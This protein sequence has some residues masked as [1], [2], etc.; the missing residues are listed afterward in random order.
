MLIYID[1]KL[2]RFY[3]NLQKGEMFMANLICAK[4]NQPINEETAVECP[5]C[6]ELYHKECWEDSENCVTCKKYNPIYELAQMQKKYEEQNPQSEEKIQDKT[7]TI[8][9]EQNIE[10]PSNEMPSSPVAN[11]VLLASLILLISGVAGG[12]ALGIYMMFPTGRDY[13][14]IIGGLAIV[15]LG[16]ALSFLVKGV[17][18][19]VNNSQK[20]AF[21]LSKLVEKQKEKEEE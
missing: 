8:D 15:G 5:F 7:N 6:W 17:A 21:Y 4:C 2:S 1:F 19:L 3:N 10:L 18:E 11:T 13:V 16:V 12:I 9:D 20:S 14:G